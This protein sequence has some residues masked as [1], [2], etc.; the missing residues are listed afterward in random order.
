MT[1]Y[2]IRRL[3][4]MIPTLIGIISI[5]FIIS[6]FVP[7]GPQDQIQAMLQGDFGSAHAGEAAASQSLN[8]HGEKK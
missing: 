7:G 6:E 2:I 8:R 4:L 3:L 5:T 1:P